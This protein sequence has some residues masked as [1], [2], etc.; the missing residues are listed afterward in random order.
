MTGNSWHR[1]N[2]SV[3][4]W[5]QGTGSN[6]DRR[7]GAGCSREWETRE[8][9]ELDSCIDEGEFEDVEALDAAVQT[10]GDN[11][12]S[13]SPQPLGAKKPDSAPFQAGGRF[14]AVVLARRLRSSPFGECWMAVKQGRSSKLVEVHLFRPEFQPRHRTLSILLSRWTRVGG[15]RH[16]SVQRLLQA[17]VQNGRYFAVSSYL[18]GKSWS[19]LLERRG[20]RPFHVATVRRIA[21][22][23]G[24]GL[25]AA[26]AADA[27]PDFI[28]PG[29]VLFDDCQRAT[30]GQMALSAHAWRRGVSRSD[31]DWTEALREFLAP[32]VLREP[33]CADVRSAIYS[34]GAT[35]YF[36]LT[37][38]LPPKDVGETNIR[39]VG[40]MPRP[41]QHRSGIPSRLDTAIA[42]AL[43]PNPNARFQNVAT[44]L[45]ALDV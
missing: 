3:Q 41:S 45:A 18:P 19:E 42:I 5:L 39:G 13:P 16:A 40:W 26:H 9:F 6:A 25:I 43:S 32:E 24:A 37:G 30:L 28:H 15:I 33:K 29:S 36:G 23:L 31:V 4:K 8:D 7:E 20:G 38:R 17:G 1:S 11:V 12:V 35:L 34:L 27:L 14:G 44:F 2:D 21:G 10:G 22:E